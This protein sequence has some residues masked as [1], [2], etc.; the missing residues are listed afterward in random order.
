MTGNF[1]NQ[2]SFQSFIIFLTFELK[3]KISLY[4][5]YKKLQIWTFYIIKKIS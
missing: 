1:R 5:F 2:Q 4:Y 3:C